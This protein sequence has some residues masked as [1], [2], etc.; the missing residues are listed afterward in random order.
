MAQQGILAKSRSRFDKARAKKNAPKKSKSDEFSTNTVLNGSAVPPDD[1]RKLISRKA[2][3]LEIEKLC[4]Q[5]LSERERRDAI[6]LLLKEALAKGRVEIKTRLEGG[7]DGLAAARA[8]SYRVDQL[9]RLLY[10]YVTKKLYPTSNP[11][12]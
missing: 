5:R 8:N 1:P 10:D 11:S 4:E 7:L 2:L 3:W 12:T 6:L 9:I